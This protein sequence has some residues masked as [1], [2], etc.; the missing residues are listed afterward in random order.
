M[1]D[2]TKKSNN[3]FASSSSPEAAWKELVDQW[4]LTTNL[5]KYVPLPM[6]AVMGDT[7]SGKSSL[8]SSLSGIELPSASTLTTKCP[9]LLHLKRIGSANP[10]TSRRRSATVSIQW[11]TSSNSNSNYKNQNQNQN[12]T[13]NNTT[14][15]KSISSY[16]LSP[17][18]PRTAE[19]SSIPPQPYPPP[20]IFQPRVIREDDD[21]D[22]NHPNKLQQELPIAIRQAQ[23]TILDYRQASLV[24][25]DIIHVYVESS[26]ISHDL[27]LVDLPGL[28]QYQLRTDGDD[29]KKESSATA[30]TTSTDATTTTTTAT[31]TTS[32]LL[33]DVQTIL[34]DYFSNDRCLLLVVL[35][36]TV[37]IHNSRLLSLARSVDPTTRRTVAV[38]TKPDLVDKGSEGDILRLITDGTTITGLTNGFY[39]VKNRGQ[40]AL[41]ANLSIADAVQQEQLFFQTTEPWNTLQHTSRLGI[42]ALGRKL[43]D[44]QKTMIHDS[45]PAICNEIQQQYDSCQQQLQAMGPMYHNPQDQRRC[46]QFLL[47]ELLRHATTSLSGKGMTRLPVPSIPNTNVCATKAVLSSS[48][49]TTNHRG[50]NTNTNINQQQQHQQQQQQ[51]QQQNTPPLLA[52]ARLHQACHDFCQHIRSGS[53]ATISI[54]VEGAHVLVTT[55]TTNRHED[56]RGEIVH[57]DEDQQ[58]ACVDY[59]DPKDH[60]TDVLFDGIGYQMD[61]ETTGV[62]DEDEVWSDGNKVFIARKF[63]FF[64]S[65]RKIPLR[66]IRT[67]PSWLLEKIALYRTD[68]LACFLNVDIFKHI[69]ADFVQEDWAPHC[70]DLIETTHQIV[71]ETLQQSLE[72][73]FGSSTSEHSNQSTNIPSTFP[74]SI[75][76]RFPLLRSMMA[77]KCM[78]VSEE[79]MKTAREQLE[80]HLDLEQHHP[81]TQDDVLLDAMASARHRSLRRELELHLRLDQEGVVFD[82]QAISDILDRVF[83]KTR[84]NPQLYLA[85]EMELVLHSYG[86]VATKRVLDRTPMICW[87]AFR[88]LPR[89][90]QEVLGCV[91]DDVLAKCFLD[92]PTTLRRHEDLS[93]QSAELKKAMGLV[94]S[95]I[96]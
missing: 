83:A 5:S 9:V 6:I 14:S 39:I 49:T 12:Q 16:S 36:A 2:E 1:P 85:E 25:P 34:H 66:Q 11:K 76:S 70:H 21:E 61:D 89:K 13:K 18:R 57:V 62:L 27:T 59:I 60:T 84:A 45:M 50:T 82:T 80:A 10:E 69:V 24:A 71:T 35:S 22:D 73:T 95:L 32:S 40:A 81:Y 87:Q 48:S 68:D 29:E 15:S 88:T 41:D 93:Q 72:T 65:L 46:Y 44:L 52:A 51:Q 86:Q 38:L 54:L 56:V 96:S 26:D 67:D 47:Q 37:D 31:T 63:Q 8:L 75:S 3:V 28:V 74:L 42:P 20:P 58:Y 43:F 90:L 17:Q 94:Q 30:T 53:L 55:T 19:S 91:T 92:S 77:Q 78:Q 79:L 33:Q 7:S 64:D 4:T 23:Q